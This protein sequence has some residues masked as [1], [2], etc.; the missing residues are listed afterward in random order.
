M[1]AVPDERETALGLE[2]VAG[3]RE[4]DVQLADPLMQQ[5]I[6]HGGSSDRSTDQRLAE[7]RRVE[8]ENALVEAVSGS[9]PPGVRD[10]RRQQCHPTAE[11]PVLGPVEVIADGALLHDQQRPGLVG[12]RRVHVSDEA[13]AQHLDDARHAARRRDDLLTAPPAPIRIR[14]PRLLTREVRNVQ[15]VLRSPSHYG[16]MAA[17]DAVVNLAAKIS[18]LSAHWSPAVVAEANGWHVKVV[19]VAGEFVWH[20]HDVDELF[21]V[22]AGHL[23][24]ELQQLPAAHLGPGD[25]FVVPAAV[26]HRPVADGVC[27]LV[28]IE[29]AETVNTGNAGGSRTTSERWL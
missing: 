10:M 4:C 22:L 18:Q 7:H 6:G 16:V 3:C 12:V 29:P 1:Q 2:S 20:S 23:V 9:S 25:V 24:I 19:K 13:G 11:S 5:R 8:V 28:L 21:L 26:N 15:D 17:P 27:D 14:S